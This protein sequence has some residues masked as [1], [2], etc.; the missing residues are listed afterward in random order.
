LSTPGGGRRADGGID[1][2]QRPCPRAS[3]DEY[4]AV[5]RPGREDREYRTIHQTNAM[6]WYFMSGVSPRA[7]D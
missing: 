2:F 3:L 4:P 1:G 7:V 6:I 5:D